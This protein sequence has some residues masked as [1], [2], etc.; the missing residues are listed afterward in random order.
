[1][2]DTKKWPSVKKPMASTNPRQGDEH[3]ASMQVV[4]FSA[5]ILVLGRRPIAVFNRAG[6]VVRK[7]DAIASKET[8]AFHSSERSALI[9][10]KA[11]PVA[12]RS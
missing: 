12:S 11:D 1:M 10:L 9:G 3:A 7:Q 2:N 8:S 4:E 6:G 5:L